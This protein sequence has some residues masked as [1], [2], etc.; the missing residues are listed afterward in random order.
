MDLHSLPEPFLRVKN[1]RVAFPNGNG[2]LEALGGV[3]FTLAQQEFI[4]VLGPSGCGKT[5]L[6]RV[7][8]GLLRPTQGQVDF[9]NGQP[10]VGMVFQQANLMPWRGPGLRPARYD[11]KRMESTGMSFI[12]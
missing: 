10:R 4:T 8:A 6:L 9:T 5:T 1:L 11:T 3:S 2:G 7:I 12:L